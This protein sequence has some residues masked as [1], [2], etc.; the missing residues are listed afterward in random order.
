MATM[1]RVGWGFA[2]CAAAALIAAPAVAQT[3]AATAQGQANPP[4]E[5]GEIIVTATKRPEAARRISASVTAFDERQLETL[6]AETL[7]DYVSRTPG[8]VFNAAVPGDS[9]A[10]IR[11]IATTTSIAQAQGTTGYFIDEVPLTDPFYSAGIP[12]IDTFDVNNVTILRGPQGTLFGSASLGGAI[13]YEAARPDLDSIGF[14]AR[15]G[16]EDSAHGG[17]GFAGHVMF[18]LPLAK[19]QFAVRGVFSRRRVAGFIDNVGTGDRNSNRTDTTG[20]RLLATFAPTDT[21]R[22]NYLFLRQTEETDDIGSAQR[23]LGKYKK[24][25]LV[26]EPFKFR[27]T[28]HNLRLDQDFSFATLTAT[29]TRHLKRFSSIQDF[30]NLVPDFAP[31][32]FLEGGTSKGTTFELRLASPTAQRFEYLVGAYH[33]STREKI[34]DTLDSP[35]AAPIFGT[36]LLLEAPVGIRGRESALFGEGT[37]HFTDQFKGSVGGRWFKTKLDTTTTQSGPFVGGT[38]TTEGGSR[39]TGFSP[40]ASLTWQPDRDHIVYA[41]VSKGFRFGG[42][43]IAVDPTFDIPSQFKSDS[44]VNYEL[45][46]RTNLLDRRL[47]LDGTLFYVDWS[48]IQVTQTSPGGFTYTANAGKARSRGV[49]ASARYAPS[50]ALQ[51]NLAITYLDAQLRRDFDPGG[52]VIP[53]GTRLPGASRWQI[54]DSVVYTFTNSSFRPTVV[55]SHRYISSAPGELAPDPVKQG[56][57]NLLDARLSGNVGRFILTAHVENIADVRGVSQAASG[58]RGPVQFLVHPRTVG[59]TLDYRL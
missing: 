39:E 19:D 56:G 54:A 43:N 15:G 57:Y 58:V 9:T 28:I 37:F 13:D 14:H 26:A 44:L 45:G 35:V 11:G 59:A 29:A 34:V 17:A 46:A 47:Q 52:V 3:D 10:I 49:E 51:L 40:K 8:A 2:G 55:L 31:V 4:A 22:V 6:G 23:A 16:I 27:T 41:L 30:T 25:T 32:S 42:P 21:T 20:G 50:A 48:D 38:I 1:R 7:A 18:N 53:A 12:D 36:S 5:P 24:D 33:D